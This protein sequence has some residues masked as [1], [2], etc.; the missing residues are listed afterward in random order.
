V[1]RWQCSSIKFQCIWPSSPCHT[2]HNRSAL[3]HN[4]SHT[5]HSRSSLSHHVSLKASPSHET[6]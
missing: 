5:M 2:T 1:Q 3:T 4:C 6:A